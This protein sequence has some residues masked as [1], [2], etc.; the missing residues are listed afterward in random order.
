[1]QALSQVNFKRKHFVALLTTF[2]HYLDYLV[3]YFG[4]LVSKIGLFLWILI[5]TI[6]LRVII[7]PGPHL[8]IVCNET[9]GTAYHEFLI[10]LFY[11]S[12]PTY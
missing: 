8:T 4:I 5:D 11:L 1:M 12:K 2:N 9:A 10:H 6:Q 3:Y 7:D